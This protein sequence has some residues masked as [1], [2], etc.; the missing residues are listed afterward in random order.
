MGIIK[1]KAGNV[2]VLIETINVNTPDTFPGMMDTAGSDGIGG[3]LLNAFE[4]ARE[5]IDGIA[6]EFLEVATNAVN[7]PDEKKVKFGMSLS[8]E[9]NLWV[10]RG[11]GSVTLNVELTWKRNRENE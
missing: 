11:E 6:E 10:L 2:E 1:S 7:P 3:K 8:T 5:V 4:S 9:G